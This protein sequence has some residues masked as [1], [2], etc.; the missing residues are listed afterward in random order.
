MTAVMVDA[1][2]PENGN[3]AGSVLNTGRQAGT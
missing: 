1:A 2:G 3:V